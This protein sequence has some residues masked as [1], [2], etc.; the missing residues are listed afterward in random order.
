MNARNRNILIAIVASVLVIGLVTGIN[1]SGKAVGS[2]SCT[3]SSNFPQEYRLDGGSIQQCPSEQPYCNYRAT[4]CCKRVRGQYTD[5]KSVASRGASSSGAGVSK[6]CGWV[7]WP[8]QVVISGISHPCPDA[9]PFCGAGNPGGTVC[10]AES[11]SGGKDPSNCI[12]VGP[13]T[14]AEDQED[15]YVD[16][17]TTYISSCTTITKSGK[18][19]LANDLV[20]KSSEDC[21]Q[22]AADGVELDCWLGAPHNR[23]GKITGALAGIS[24][25]LSAGTRNSIKITNCD[26]RGSLSGI[27]FRKVRHSEIVNNYFYKNKIGIWFNSEVWNTVI[28]NNVIKGTISDGEAISI[29]DGHNIKI[30]SNTIES[31]SSANGIYIEDSSSSSLYG[32]KVT[33]GKNGI[34]IK[35]SDYTALEANRVSDN[36]HYDYYCKSSVGIMRHDRLPLRGFIPNSFG[37]ISDACSSWRAMCGDG[38]LQEG[39]HCE[40]DDDCTD[41]KS[42]NAYC[43]CEVSQPLYKD[44]KLCDYD[45]WGGMWTCIGYF[46]EST[47]CKAK[48]YLTKSCNDF[49]E[50]YNYNRG[51]E[52][53]TTGTPRCRCFF[54]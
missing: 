13:E 51:E 24:N 7:G 16:E 54:N 3:W 20:G 8:Q 25:L 37:K 15:T 12:P 32:N 40:K 44:Y 14:P 26:M 34:V 47:S 10:C 23:K 35:G 27:R 6:A 36:V 39:E 4:S 31:E 45:C 9:H 52:I 2:M 1:I 28:K 21:I 17:T 53:S 22:I 42:C 11:S 30:T 49:C 41:S 38:L 29:D 33:E 50:D 43:N 48:T 19:K 18:Y 5:C 46:L